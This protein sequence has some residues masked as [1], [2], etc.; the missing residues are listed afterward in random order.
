MQQRNSR[1]FESLVS[2]S[3]AHCVNILSTARLCPTCDDS[4]LQR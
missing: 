4:D 3:G 1:M 2:L